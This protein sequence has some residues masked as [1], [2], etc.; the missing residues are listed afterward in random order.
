MENNREFKQVPNVEIF[1]RNGAKAPW[2]E[3]QL[4]RD[5]KVVRKLI[6]RTVQSFYSETNDLETLFSE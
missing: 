3:I 2:I 4:V 6:A 1:I 5:G